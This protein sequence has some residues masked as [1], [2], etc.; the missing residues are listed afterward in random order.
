MITTASSTIKPTSAFIE[1]GY[2]GLGTENSKLLEVLR[3]QHLHKDAAKEAKL[4][5]C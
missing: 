2:N 5:E 1:I 3:I 4:Q